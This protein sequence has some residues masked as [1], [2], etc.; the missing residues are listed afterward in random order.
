MGKTDRAEAWATPHKRIFFATPQAFNNDASKG[1]Q[2]WVSGRNDWE[3]A[4]AAAQLKL[5]F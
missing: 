5:K 2:T 3:L 4:L 1:E